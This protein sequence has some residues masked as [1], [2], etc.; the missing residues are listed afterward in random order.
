MHN[1]YNCRLRSCITSSG[2][3]TRQPSHCVSDSGFVYAQAPQLAAH[4]QAMMPMY[5]M[6]MPMPPHV[7]PGQTAVP[8][9]MAPPLEAGQHVVHPSAYNKSRGTITIPIE[10]YEELVKA[11]IHLDS[12]R[13]L[14]YVPGSGYHYQGGTSIERA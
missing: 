9:V 7:M 14:V 12:I 5:P 8:Q 1:L 3:R 2:G 13:R 11:K 6:A 4:Q 10:E